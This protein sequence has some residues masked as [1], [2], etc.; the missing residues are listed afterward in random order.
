MPCQNDWLDRAP[1]G[2][3]GQVPTVNPDSEERYGYSGPHTASSVNRSNFREPRKTVDFLGMAAIGL[4]RHCCGGWRLLRLPTRIT[5][6][7]RA[8][9]E[10]KILGNGIPAEGVDRTAVACWRIVLAI[11]VSFVSSSAVFIHW[12]S[13]R[14]CCCLAGSFS[15][16]N[17]LSKDAIRSS[18]VAA[19]LTS[20]LCLASRSSLA[21]SSGETSS[22]GT[23]NV[24]GAICASF[25]DAKGTVTLAF[26]LAASF[27]TDTAPRNRH[28][29]AMP[30]QDR[31]ELDRRCPGFPRCKL[32]VGHW[33]SV[34]RD[35]FFV[36]NDRPPY[37][38]LN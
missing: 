5:L 29:S 10:D 30:V 25:Q 27:G 35:I 23:S 1:E 13:S 19:W 28:P 9:E 22:M 6:L 17:R 2:R 8:F 31:F 4:R 37:T 24:A 26:V 38:L 33:V 14:S 21:S 15:S 36:V 32:K 7:L 12:I 11:K 16:F 20:P 34:S 18:T 3:S